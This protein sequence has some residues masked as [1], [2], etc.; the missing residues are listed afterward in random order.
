MTGS[1]GGRGW[2]LGF[3]FVGGTVLALAAGAVVLV[4]PALVVPLWLGW[5]ALV[6]GP[7]LIATYTRT[8][9]DART[10]RERA[11]MLLGSL[12]WLLPGFVALAAG[13]VAFQ[14]YLVAATLWSIHHNAR[15][16]YGILAI[17][18]RH[19]RAGAAARRRDVGFLYLALWGMFALFL[20]GHPW[21]Q[22]ELPVTLPSPVLDAMAIALAA[23]A[24]L[25]LISVVRDLLRG[26]DPRPALFVLFPVVGVQAFAL[27]VVARWEPLVP[28]PADPEQAFLAIAFIGGIVHGL[29]YLG[30]VLAAN[31]RRAAAQR[32]AYRPLL[33]YAALVAASL[34]YLVLN[35]GRGASPW[36][37]FTE[38]GSLAARVW[39]ALYWGLFFHHYVLDAKI[40]RPHAD[41]VVRA[42]LGL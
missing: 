38:P 42:E 33:V 19:A 31:R 40:W 9:L 22:R 11:A 5:L 6:D 4:A 23:A 26:A 32:R 30:V 17:Y 15:Q 3:F 37:T 24:A 25:Y 27:L 20:L 16:S 41:A 1:I 18:E 14:L 13:D 35:L 39:L 12:A 10:R 21:N 28:H 34:L 36:G 8:Y 2:D 7:H 29:Q